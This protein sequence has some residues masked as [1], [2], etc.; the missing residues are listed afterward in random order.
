MSMHDRPLAQSCGLTAGGLNLGVTHGLITAFAN[1]L[2]REQL[3]HVGSLLNPFTHKC[4]YLVR[5]SRFLIQRLKRSNDARTRN[6]LAS[7]R[8]S[9]VSVNGRA[10]ALN[11]RKSRHQGQVS[12]SARV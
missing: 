9:Q 1:A 5:S 7:N 10:Q 11:R 12:I 2:S 6:N 8:I 4:T 3:D